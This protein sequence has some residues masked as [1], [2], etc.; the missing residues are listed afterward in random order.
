M[1]I[2]RRRF[3]ALS[4]SV[5]L[6]ACTSS[7][8]DGEAPSTDASTP[9][10]SDPEPTSTP[11]IT[12]T[13]TT[14]TT[15]T[16]TSAPSPFTENPFTFGIGSGDPDDGSVVLW[17]RLGGD[18]PDGDIEVNWFADTA[19]GTSASGSV[20]T[21]AELG[22]SVHVVAEVD[23]PCEF[24][25]S[26][27]GWD[28][29]V[30]RTSPVLDGASEYRIAAASCQHYETGFYAA[31]RDIAEWAPD[32]V[33]FL[34]DFIYEGDAQ[35]DDG[36][37]RIVRSHEGTEPTDLDGYRARYATYL[38]DPN[39]QASRAAAPWLAIWDDHEVENNYAGLVSQP[40][41]EPDQD[42]AVFAARRAAA[43]RAWWENTPTRLAMPELDRDPTEPFP[44]HRGVDV[45]DLLRISALDGRQFRDDQVSEATLDAGPPAAGWDDPTRTMLGAEQEAWI[46]DRFS[47][48]TATWNCVAQQTILSDTRLP[49][50]AILNYD[51]WDGYHPARQ[52]LLDAAP[53]N[54]VTLTGDIH[55]AGIG[56]VGPVD[57]PVG[58][59][60]V[61]TAV[62]ST[63]NVDPALADVVLSIPSIVDANL[64]H[65]GYTRHTV[66]R[67]AWNAE[68]RQVEDVR[69][70][71]S[72]V[73]TW[74]TF[75]V[76]AGIA[77]VIE[78]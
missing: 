20:I 22:H 76:A 74:K 44:I 32:L 65:R 52:R 60:F 59:E 25:F 75:A 48:S 36:S 47:S 39:L 64:V 5:T 78:V 71:D 23:G 27:P 72:E 58:I 33:V 55:L 18:L 1:Q 12:T 6:A 42:P 31:H 4:A 62:S 51:Q 19:D 50:G 57:A 10:T 66:G 28:S 14:T 37:G 61:T 43:F 29:S 69:D 35:T 3:L 53:A 34:G 17:T 45:G 7:D 30:G 21:N 9:P 16:S 24:G 54:F 2:S 40:D 38:S 11:A 77:D 15:T 46:T 70:P 41:E 26:V 73:T 49:N 63:A 67:D 13:T 56:R 8:D 68:Y